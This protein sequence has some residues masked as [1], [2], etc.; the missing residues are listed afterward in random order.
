MHM[1]FAWASEASYAVPFRVPVIAWLVVPCTGVSTLTALID[2]L[3]FWHPSGLCGGMY[4][5]SMVYA[6]FG[7][8]TAM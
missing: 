5:M 6:I 3:L 2:P 7:I 1:R 4:H 8:L